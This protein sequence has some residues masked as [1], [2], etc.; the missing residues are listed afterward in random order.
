M[1]F[2]CGAAVGLT[3]GAVVSLWFRRQRD[4]ERARLEELWAASAAALASARRRT[5]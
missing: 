1:F 5:G 2:A 3:V 4:R